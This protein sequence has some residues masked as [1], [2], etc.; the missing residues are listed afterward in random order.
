MKKKFFI[1]VLT[2]FAALCLGLFVGC[3]FLGGSGDTGNSTEGSSGGSDIKTGLKAPESVRLDMSY[4]RLYIPDCS[5]SG[6]YYYE[7]QE[8][9]E[10]ASGTVNKTL[11][12]L[13]TEGVNATDGYY[14]VSVTN[15][16]EHDPFD[17]T[18]ICKAKRNDT[19]S[20]SKTFTFVQGGSVIYDE[21][22]CTL[23]FETRLFTWTEVEDAVGYRIGLGNNY[24]NVT[25]PQ[26]VLDG[27]YYSMSVT[28]LFDGYKF[29]VA[30]DIGLY[31][32]KADIRYDEASNEFTWNEND[33]TYYT[34]EITEGGETSSYNLTEERLLYVPTSDRLTIKVTSYRKLRIPAVS[35]VTCDV[36]RVSGLSVGAYTRELSWSAV[37]GAADY[38]VILEYGNGQRKVQQATQPRLTVD[39]I[40][41]QVKAR[42][43]PNLSATLAPTIT[44]YTEFD[45]SVYMVDELS[46]SISRDSATGKLV[47]SLSPDATC[48]E[49]Y[50][51][52]ITPEGG[53]KQVTDAHT[54]TADGDIS[55]QADLPLY[56]MIKLEISR[57]FR[58]DEGSYCF[59]SSAHPFDYSGN[60]LYVEPFQVTVKNKN[61]L[62]ANERAFTVGVD[63]PEA[64]EGRTDFSLRCDYTDEPYRTASLRSGAEFTL[65]IKSDSAQLSIYYYSRNDK[66]TL[67][68]DVFQK[69][70]IRL[71]RVSL[72]ADAQKISW[73][74]VDGA[75]IYRVEKSTGGDYTEVSGGTALRYEH[76]VT[77]VGEYFYRVIAI[78]DDPFVMDSE[79]DVC[80]VKKLAAPTISLNGSG[81]IVIDSSDKDVDFVVLL[82]GAEKELT[83]NNLLSALTSKTTA[84]LI[85]RSTRES[86]QKA[87]YIGSEPAERTLH[88]IADLSAIEI[89]VDAA[90]NK[91]LMPILDTA[92]E[93]SYRI[94]R[95][96]SEQDPYS[97]NK[98]RDG[99]YSEFSGDEFLLGQ[100]RLDIKPI[101]R[102]EGADIY[103]Y[104]GDVVSDTF[105][106]D[107]IRSATPLD[108]GLG[109]EIT[110]SL[111]TSVEVL[112]WKV[113]ALY[114]SR[115]YLFDG[116]GT[117]I[118][119]ENKNL[120]SDMA[121]LTGT[122]TGL[123]F[124]VNYGSDAALSQSKTLKAD[125]F[126][127]EVTLVQS[128]P[129]SRFSGSY[130]YV[131]RQDNSTPA[132]AKVTLTP[133]DNKTLSAVE[134]YTVVYK[135]KELRADNASAVFVSE[136]L[137]NEVL[138]PVGYERIT[139][140]FYLSIESDKFLETDGVIRFY[141]SAT[142]RQFAE[143]AWY[144]L[145]LQAMYDATISD[146]SATRISND[147][148]QIS[149]TLSFNNHEPSGAQE[150]FYLEYR[151]DDGSWQPFLID[152][153]V[154]ALVNGNSSFDFEW[155]EPDDLYFSADKVLHLRVKSGSCNYNV[156]YLR[157][158]DWTY[159]TLT[160]PRR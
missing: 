86:T 41:G 110:S 76:G 131:E 69:D 52:V 65:P 56:T 17:L 127:V 9:Y 116:G 34:V 74:A 67:L 57:K 115:E 10:N 81:E 141:K 61:A 135:Q 148:T 32:P 132:Q 51:V 91:V 24:F 25:Q 124:S 6:V 101:N 97:L 11:N 43:K 82:D 133:T 72:T 128:E 153:K 134:N 109:F 112:G 42:I 102:E 150:S 37:T 147:K 139:R 8:S 5:A 75:D 119:T 145:S 12:S 106:K 146:V 78:S 58:G 73:Q 98:S 83:E 103:L 18:V 7:I 36:V 38:S 107:G 14:D 22:H 15:L 160:V 138:V 35:E 50:S 87:V 80:T 64:I 140:I 96:V 2:V 156:T 117:V 104:L 68:S 155:N 157:E 122:V 120:I 77:D 149:F 144:A 26:V 29:G 48:V 66:F 151:A 126:K 53:Q 19:K 84:T 16:V 123:Y 54:D 92:N 89:K 94:Y 27:Y 88:R 143:N 28:P 159:L 55:V 1:L 99:Y 105:Q 100:Y 49:S 60:V 137:G 90:E 44:P 121:D 30:T 33:D 154:Y 62:L 40:G 59:A 111:Y 79:A 70:I 47:V 136:T 125:R 114:S 95:R 85:A 118:I 20:V 108:D 130:E 13:S 63:I 46:P 142:E 158:S 129:V 3:S 71:D 23:D 93:Y 4:K 39:S 45:F 21:E 113:N 152:G 31:T